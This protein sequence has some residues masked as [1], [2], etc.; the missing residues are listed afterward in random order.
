MQ[1]V[2]LRSNSRGIHGTYENAKHHAKSLIPMIRT[3]VDAVQ[4][5]GVFVARVEQWRQAHNIHIF[6]TRNGKYFV[7]RPIWLKGEGYVGIYVNRYMGRGKEEEP[8]F[9]IFHDYRN[10]VD[11][12]DPVDFI[13]KEA[14]TK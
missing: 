14:A 1:T 9:E 2:L 13:K 12:T 7:F 5:D 10:N 6:A 11:W 3:L 4:G 8:L